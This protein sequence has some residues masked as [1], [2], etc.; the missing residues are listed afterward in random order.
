MASVSVPPAA[1][2]GQAGHSH[3]RVPERPLE[4]NS[5]GDRCVVVFVGLFQV[6]HCKALVP[7]GNPSSSDSVW[8]FLPSPRGPLGWR[9][10]GQGLPVS[11]SVVSAILAPSAQL[12]LTWQPGAMARTRELDSQARV[13]T[14]LLSSPSTV[15]VSLLGAFSNLR[16]SGENRYSGPQGASHPS[17]DVDPRFEILFNL[18]DPLLLGGG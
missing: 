6:G 16:T 2:A 15:L 7:A 8:L 5:S 13:Y 11:A 1:T 4:P 3:S 18:P 14:A 17:S 9:P 12:T 10:H